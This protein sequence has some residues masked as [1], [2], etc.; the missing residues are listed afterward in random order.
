M[1]HVVRKWFT[2]STRQPGS[3][4]SLVGESKRVF[5]ALA[6]WGEVF[7]RLW[8]PGRRWSELVPRMSSGSGRACNEVR[9]FG[10]GDAGFVGL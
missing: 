5:K 2:L 7:R 9:R 1:K 8:R 3:K 6:K 10:V 4:E